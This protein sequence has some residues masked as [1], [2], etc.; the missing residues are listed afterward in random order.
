M[1]PQNRGVRRREVSVRP[2]QASPG[3]EEPDGEQALAPVVSTAF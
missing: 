2:G 1:Q 3:P